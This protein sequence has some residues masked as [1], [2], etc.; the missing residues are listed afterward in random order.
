MIKKNN[1]RHETIS[2]IINYPNYIHLSYR[3]IMDFNCAK[4][5]TLESILPVKAQI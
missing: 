3:L 1:F 2:L 4:K 5:I